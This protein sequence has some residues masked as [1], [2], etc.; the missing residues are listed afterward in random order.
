MYYYHKILERLIINLSKLKGK[1][2]VLPFVDNSSLKSTNHLIKVSNFLNNLSKI[3]NEKSISLALETDL[4]PNEFIDLLKTIATAHISINYDSGNSASLG[5]NIID[6][7]DIY[8]NLYQ[9]FI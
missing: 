5:F 7:L 3:C 9:I 8:G 4:E 6:E 1:V 2:I